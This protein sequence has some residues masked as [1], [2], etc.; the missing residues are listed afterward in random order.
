IEDPHTITYQKEDIFVEEGAK[1][2]AAILNAQEGPI[3]IG[4]NVLIQP[5]A[6]IQGPVALCHHAHISPG[7]TIHGATTIG[8]YARVGGEVRNAV[9]F[10][11]TNKSHEGFL[12]SSVLGEWCNIGAGTSVSNLRNN[13]GPVKVWSYPKFNFAPTAL[14]FCGLLMGDHSKCAVNTAFNTGT[15]VGVSANVFKHEFSERFIPSF[16][17]GNKAQQATFQL[18]K[19]FTTAARMMERR[20]VALTEADK[21]I[22]TYVYHRSSIYRS[23]DR[24]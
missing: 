9:I 20:N 4:K 17:W 6:V 12:G 19:A 18:D 2:Q 1:M 7:A 21:K 15:V 10:G 24:P 23:Q 13:Y 14:Q 11:Y 3:Y 16:T 5:G 8:P 22:L